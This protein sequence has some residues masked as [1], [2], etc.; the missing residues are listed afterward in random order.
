MSNMSRR[1][2]SGTSSGRTPSS[3]RGQ[4]Q[5]TAPRASPSTALGV[6]ST[7]QQPSFGAAASGALSTTLAGNSVSLTPRDNRYAAAAKRLAFASPPRPDDLAGN[8]ARFLNLHAGMQGKPVSRDPYTYRDPYRIQDN[9]EFSSFG[10]PLLGK[11]KAIEYKPQQ[12]I[13]SSGAS[14]SSSIQQQ[15]HPGNMALARRSAPLT[16][17]NLPFTAAAGVGSSS[18]VGSE[19]SSRSSRESYQTAQ[20][21]VSFGTQ[22]ERSRPSNQLMRLRTTRSEEMLGGLGLNGPDLSDSRNLLSSTALSRPQD[23]PNAWYAGSLS[24]PST[25]SSRSSSA[26]V[27]RGHISTS[28][29]IRG[30]SPIRAAERLSLK[31]PR[32]SALQSTR[33]DDPRVPK[34]RAR[35]P[36]PPSPQEAQPLKHFRSQGGSKDGTSLLSRQWHTE[37]THFRSLQLRLDDHRTSV[38]RQPLANPAKSLLLP[39]AYIRMD[40]T[41]LLD[42]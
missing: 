25:A 37:E 6:R 23:H 31:S 28:S 35:F 22:L 8:I 29:S 24:L 26:T 38:P 1:Q 34:Q 32:P 27:G 2:A 30:D 16:L 41:R 13:G 4:Q 3:P 33:R 5:L 7:R 19:G 14:G 15:N 20:S 18:N 39:D 9:D 11:G 21:N 36:A 10:G 17:A 42:T 12:L 40:A